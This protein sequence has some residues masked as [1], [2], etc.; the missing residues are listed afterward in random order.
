M[1]ERS[2]VDVSLGN[3][4]RER[5]RDL[6][7]GLHR[8]DLPHFGLRRFGLLFGRRQRRFRRRITGPGRIQILGRNQPGLRFVR[9][10]QPGISQVRLFVGRLGAQNFSLGASF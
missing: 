6:R 3:H 5:G 2:R 1:D 4:A 10:S 7:V 9:R 8:F